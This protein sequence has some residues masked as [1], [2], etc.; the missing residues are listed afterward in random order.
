[1]KRTI[2]L[3]LACWIVAC[4][5]PDSHEEKVASFTADSAMVV[6][7]HPLASKIGVDI[8]KK[9]GNAVDAV[10][11]VQFAL[12]VTFPEAGNIG[13]GGFML[14]RTK[15]G[16]FSSLDYR[17][18]APARATTNMFLDEKG[19]VIKESSTFGHLAS[20]IPG[21]VEGMVEAYKKFGTLPWKDL[22]QPAIDLAL[23]GVALTNRAAEDLNE[24]QGDLKKYNSVVPEFL[25]HGWKAGDTLHWT[26]LAHTLERIRDKG[27][28]GFYEGETAKLFAAEMHRGKGIV[29]EEDLK[30]YKSKWRAPLVAQYKN[31]KVISVPPPSSGGVAL[32]QLLKS[33]EPYPVKDWGVNAVKTI[34]LMT[35]AEQR[36][37]ADRATWLG[38]PDFSKIPV[39]Q[40][41][42][43]RYIDKRMS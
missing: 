11:A 35:E 10:I 32:I 27:R 29:T 38:D 40:L 17:E 39:D 18:K 22:V 28:A 9:G 36:V 3:L 30:N 34:H 6:S 8:L 12:T 42:D 23:R 25:I 13:G 31:Y 15:E 37:Y 21:S 24:L 33:V 7:A 2:I 19:N 20:G 5:S 1:M 43:D 14:V 26:D 16:L 41:I 4:H